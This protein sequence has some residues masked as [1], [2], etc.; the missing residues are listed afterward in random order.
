V[1]F[2]IDRALPKGIKN[3]TLSYTF[4]EVGAGQKVIKGEHKSKTSKI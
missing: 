1:V 3:I 4:F 2:I